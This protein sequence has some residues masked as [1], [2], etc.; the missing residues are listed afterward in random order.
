MA[1]ANKQRNAHFI[2]QIGFVMRPRSG[3]TDTSTREA[4]AKLSHNARQGGDGI[5]ATDSPRVFG[6][7]STCGAASFDV[8]VAAARHLKP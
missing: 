2:Q 1:P 5:R 6:K 3:H 4:A 8:G 7:A